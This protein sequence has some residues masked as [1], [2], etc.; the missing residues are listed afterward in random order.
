V[1]TDLFVTAFGGAR[2]FRNLRNGKFEDVT[3][4]AG[5]PVPG[6]SSGAAFFDADLDEDLDLFVARYVKFDL[7]HLPNAGKPCG[8]RGIEVACGPHGLEPETDLF[9]ENV[10][11]GRFV[12][13]TKKFGFDKAP[14]A[15]G[16]GVIAFDFDS[17]GD[18]DLYVAND[19][20][21]NDLWENKRGSFVEVAGSL[22]CDL[23]EGGRAQASMGLD[24]ADVDLDG[25][26][27][28]F[29]TNFEHDTNTLYLNVNDGRVRGFFDATAAAGLGAPS[30]SQLAWGTRIVDFD[31]DGWPDIV[32]ANGHI[33]PQVDQGSLETSYAQKNQLFRSLGKNERGQIR[34]EEAAPA[35]GFFGQA[36]V[37]R[38][39]L[40]ADFDDDGDQD[41]FVVRMDAQPML[42]R[43]DTPSAGH[44]IGVVLAGKPPNRDAIGAV[45]VVED[46]SNVTR[47]IER[48][49]GAG[50]YS[51]SDPRLWMALG[52]ATIK[53]AKVIWPDGT[54]AALPASGLDRYLRVDQTSGLVTEWKRP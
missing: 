6:W 29:A 7:D 46:S 48:T 54:S 40:T 13:A 51:T 27:D 9:F 36:G 5:V 1:R 42:G 20:M 33:Y 23:G 15:Y 45:L 53:S 14:P 21:A 39:L 44:W 17:D 24:A 47:R 22:G 4:A 10:G 38:G 26:P 16:L 8:Y 11:G 37:N 35:G 41:L 32:I 12:D 25:R 31:R 19:S 49:Y 3:Q 28:I 2:L 50:F 52:P 18:M 34:F 30:F 43:N